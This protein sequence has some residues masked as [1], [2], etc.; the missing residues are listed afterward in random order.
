[1]SRSLTLSGIVIVLVLAFSAWAQVMVTPE[2]H[3][4]HPV[5]SGSTGMDAALGVDEQLGHKIPLETRFRD[6]TGRVVTLKE[7]IKG[8][9]IIL[10]VYYSCT[11]VCNFLQSGL[12]QVLPTLKPQPLT[13]YR[14]ISLS[15]DDTETPALAARYQKTYLNAMGIPFPAD[16]WHF[17]TGDSANIQLFTQAVG[18]HFQRRGRDFIHPVVSLI[19][20]GDG[21]IVRYLYGTTFLPKDLTLALWEAR[22]G[23]VGGAVRKVVNYCFSFDPTNK[24]YTFRLLRISATVVILSAGSFLL[25]LIFSSKKRTPPSQRNR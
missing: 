11:N 24:T 5:A 18:Y 17:L 19:V 6:E 25:F 21:T 1:M 13:D 4:H 8:P 2:P 23:K 20:S 10:P 14:V 22:S 15:F 7:L 9:T 12:A 3:H 16:G